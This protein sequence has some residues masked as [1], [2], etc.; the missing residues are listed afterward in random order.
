MCSVL[1]IVIKSV[2]EVIDKNIKVK[3]Y[4]DKTSVKTYQVSDYPVDDYTKAAL[5][6][7]L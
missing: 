5:C 7:N 4:I 1:P 2:G 6:I 3:L